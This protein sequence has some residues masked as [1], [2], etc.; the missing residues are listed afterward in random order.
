MDDRLHPKRPT[1]SRRARLLA[2]T[3]LVSGLVAG[4]GGSSHS[5]TVATRSGAT[6]PAQ[7]TTT[8]TTTTVATGVAPTPSAPSG[9][10]LDCGLDPCY[11]PH[12]FRVTYGIQPLLNSG[13]DGRGETV[14]VLV[15]AAR[16]KRRTH[17][18]P[19][20]FGEL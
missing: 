19:S 18:S 11:T 20:G 5:Q 16:P 15:P 13:I 1:R 8:T 7:A 4:C 14:T 10:A 12:Q 2:L 17:R 9:A 3:T 6:G